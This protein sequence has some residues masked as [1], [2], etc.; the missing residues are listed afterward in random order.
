MCR[1]SAVGNGGGVDLIAFVVEPCDGIRPKRLLEGRGICCVNLCF[2]N[3][4]RPARKSI[5]VLRIR[6]FGWDRTG[7]GRHVALFHFLCYGLISDLPR[8]GKHDRCIRVVRYDGII[9]N[10]R[11]VRDGF[12]SGRV[13]L[14]E[15]GDDGSALVFAGIA[16]AVGQGSGGFL[17]RLPLCRFFFLRSRKLFDQLLG[18]V[19]T[20]LLQS[21]LKPGI[22]GDFGKVEG[23]EVGK[24]HIADQP[25]HADNLPAPNLLAL[26]KS[27]PGTPLIRFTEPYDP[28]SGAVKDLTRVCIYTAGGAADAR[29]HGAGADFQALVPGQRCGHV[30]DE[31]SG[32]QFDLQLPPGLLDDNGGV[33]V[34]LDGLG[35]IQTDIGIAV[36]AGVHGVA[37][38]Q[39]H[40]LAVIHSYTAGV[41]DRNA[42]LHQFQPHD[43][44]PGIGGGCGHR[45]PQ[46]DHQGQK[47]G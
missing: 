36:V 17:R 38:V 19:V 2:H 25:S 8:D 44:S 13:I 9:G 43:G 3:L 1:D 35:F 39:L 23:G 42:A 11:M 4:R 7:I 15:S 47:E 37:A 34:Q 14:L 27:I 16:A 30:E 5:A 18:I 26:G 32:L 10:D 24:L 41:S 45:Q 31:L 12:G 20:L 40:T 33:H 21:I 46:R 28:V 22:R 29:D 6:F